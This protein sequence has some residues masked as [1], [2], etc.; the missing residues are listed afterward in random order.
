M[1]AGEAVFDW[2]EM[3]EFAGDPDQV[4]E[5]EII[6]TNS[7]HD[8]MA[9]IEILDSTEYIIAFNSSAFDPE[10]IGE[11]VNKISKNDGR[12]DMGRPD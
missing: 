10:S 5:G 2:P 11:R 7:D 6:A 1:G 3:L 8:I 9:E 12:S 4:Y